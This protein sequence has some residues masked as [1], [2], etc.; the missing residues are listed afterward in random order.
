[1]T[2]AESPYWWDTK[3]LR[4][5]GPDGRFVSHEYVHRAVVRFLDNAGGEVGKVTGDMIAG[6]VEIGEWQVRMARLIKSMHLAAAAANNGGF[7][8]LTRDDYLTVAR[9]LKFNYKRLALFAKRVEQG[10]LSPAQILVRAD[11]YTSAAYTGAENVRATQH[12][13]QGY[14]EELRILGAAEHCVDCLNE[15]SRGWIPIGE[16]LAIGET[17]CTVRCKCRKLYR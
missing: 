8:N 11:M 7:N 4:Y 14:T 3:S 17:A 10:Q 16:G 12:K 9:A 15:A 13:R 6:R 1:M 5:R 2:I